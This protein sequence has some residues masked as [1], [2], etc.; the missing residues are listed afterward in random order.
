MRWTS[1]HIRIAVVGK[2]KSPAWTA[3]Q[4]DYLERIQRYVPVQLIEVKDVV[5]KGMTDAAAL[6]QEGK[7]LLK[8]TASTR[9]LIALTPMGKSFDSPAWSA[10]LQKQIETYQQ[11]AFVIGGP[12]GLAPDVLQASRSQLSLSSMTFPHEL[13]RVIFLEQLYRA[14]TLLNGEKYH[15]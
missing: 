1:A 14:F 8:E 4:S 11:I 15:K 3:A 12:A 7:A 5:G 2:L 13:A 6:Q 10:M 9:S